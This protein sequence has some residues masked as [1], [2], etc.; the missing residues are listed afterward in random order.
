MNGI[1]VKYNYRQLVTEC[2]DKLVGLCNRWEMDDS[3]KRHYD[4][5][6]R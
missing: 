1:N 3:D 5:R 2:R 6:S 4:I